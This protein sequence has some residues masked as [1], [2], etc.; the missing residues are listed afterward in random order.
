MVKRNIPKMFQIVPC[1]KSGLPANVTKFRSSIF[2]NVVNMHIAY[3][4]TKVDT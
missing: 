2:R 1:L 3:Q 4:P